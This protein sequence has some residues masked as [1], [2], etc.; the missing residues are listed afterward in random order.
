MK[1]NQL[2]KLGKTLLV[3]SFFSVTMFT[4]SVA[5]AQSG[6]GINVTGAPANTSSGLDVDFN[7]KGVL[8]PRIALS[9]TTDVLTIPSPANSLLVFNT[10]TSGGLTPGFYYYNTA[11]S[12]WT[13]VAG[14]GGGGFTLACASPQEDMT[15]VR[16][17][18]QWECTDILE[19]DPTFNAVSIN[20]FSGPNSSYDLLVAG[21]VG[22]DGS[23]TP[24]PSYE[25]SVGGQGHFTNEVAIGTT[26][27]TSYDLR[28]NG[29]VGIGFSPNS[30]FDLSVSGEAH[31]SSRLSVGTTTSAPT[32]GFR[33]NGNIITGGT[34]SCTTS[35]INYATSNTTGTTIILASGVLRTVS[36]SLRY[37]ENIKDLQF[38]KSKILSIRPVSFNYKESGSYNVGVIAE[39]VEQLIPELVIYDR[40]PMLDE[41]GEKMRDEN[42]TYLF[43]E[44]WR[45]ESVN[46][47][48]IAMSLIPIVREHEQ[49]IALQNKEISALKLALAAQQAELA[50][51][52]EV[53][54][55]IS[56]QK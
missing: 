18:G 29:N 9:S 34:I 11:L 4:S 10:T 8:I 21:N 42:G 22:I 55:K 30:S 7:N 3:C 44:E 39:E 40:V 33:S 53:V 23:G 45:P 6:V 13:A 32:N 1:K 37:K 48:G 35:G 17:S 50:K 19:I 43:K 49:T 12:Q 47:D 15:L 28:V 24:N 2:S 36:S 54:F 20:N 14:A 26:P 46:Y 5:N 25:L 51:L 38:D 31:V 52:V 27:S 41:K 56:A 16:N